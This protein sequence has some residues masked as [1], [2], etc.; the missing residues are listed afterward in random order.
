[1]KKYFL[2]FSFF[3]LISSSI[4]GYATNSSS[5]NIIPTPTQEEV[6]PD[7][8]LN[9]P[10]TIDSYAEYTLKAVMIFDEV[11]VA[12]YD[13]EKED[14]VKRLVF[15]FDVKNLTTNDVNAG[16]FINIKITYKDDYTY[17]ISD[18]L[19]PGSE[20][21]WPIANEKLIPLKV[22]ELYCLIDIPDEVAL[23]KEDIKTKITLT[24]NKY[25]YNGN[26]DIVYEYIAQMQQFKTELEGITD[27]L[28]NISTRLSYT[29]S[30]TQNDLIE[31][32]RQFGVQK[33]LVDSLLENVS[34]ITP[35]E[36][37]KEGHNNLVKGI[38]KIQEG[39][40]LLANEQSVSNPDLYNENRTQAGELDV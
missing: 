1:M 38:E 4:A 6:F 39:L 18:F 24:G 33:K 10:V 32:S 36:F 21:S 26:I 25:Q 20:I 22:T 3:L 9:Q 29:F 15:I 31:F 27:E 16:D 7:I 2:L 37:Y 23:S 34:K 30:P 19:L 28:G 40:G 35:P 11:K 17:K 14:G 13:W 5:E 8:N 12:Y